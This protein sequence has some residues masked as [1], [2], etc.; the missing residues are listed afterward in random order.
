MKL[1]GLLSWFDEPERDLRRAIETFHAAGMT[2][3]VAVDGAYGIFPGGAATSP[4][5]QRRTIEQTCERLG[6]PV[7]VHEPSR[8]WP[9]ETEKRALMFGLAERRLA[10][11]LADWF[12]VLDADEYVSAP[13]DL[14]SR[15]AAVTAD[16]VNVAVLEPA[17]AGRPRREFL[18]RKIFRALP[19]LTVRWNH[20]TYATPD[21]RVL[22]GSNQVDA[23]TMRDVQVVHTT[24]LRRAERRAVKDAYYS[25]RDELG[26]ESNSR[27]W[28]CGAEATHTMRSNFTYDP[29]DDRLDSTLFRACDAHLRRLMYDNDLAI[30]R[31][32]GQIIAQQPIR[33]EQLA[34]A[35]LAAYLKPHVL[36]ST[37]E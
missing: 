1:I 30:K 18:I 20:H 5:G 36:H 32:L 34:A 15:L 28:R 23:E 14:P 24:N 12:I 21:G 37:R 33:D 13:V 11:T 6:I 2:H 17:G 29:V 10:T 4:P 7:V 26:I 25:A 16:A 3:L 31:I 27:C 9:T 8:T 19:G 22:W 35:K